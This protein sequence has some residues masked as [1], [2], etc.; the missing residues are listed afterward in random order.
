MQEGRTALISMVVIV[1]IDIHIH[2]HELQAS[3]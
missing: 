3:E 1:E 2:I